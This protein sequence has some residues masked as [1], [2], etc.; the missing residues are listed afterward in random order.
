[1]RCPVLFRQNRRPDSFG[2]P[3]TV[4]PGR[5]NHEVEFAAAGLPVAVLSS[6]NQ[7]SSFYHPADR[8]TAPG[9]RHEQPWKWHRIPAGSMIGSQRDRREN[10]GDQKDRNKKAVQ[11]IPDRFS[12]TRQKI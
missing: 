10:E 6:L 11:E 5:D 7:D 9:A 3:H 8:A 1:M 12:E 4:G 2:H